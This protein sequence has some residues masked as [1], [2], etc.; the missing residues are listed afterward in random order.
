[1]KWYEVR[2]NVEHTAAFNGCLVLIYIVIGG[3]LLLNL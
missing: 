1:M 2:R 3:C